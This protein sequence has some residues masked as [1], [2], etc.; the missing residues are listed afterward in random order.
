MRADFRCTGSTEESRFAWEQEIAGTPFERHLSS[1][2]GRDQARARPQGGTEVR[3]TSRHAPEGALAAGIPDAEPRPGDDHR[4][5][6]GR[7]RESADGR[8]RR[9]IGADERAAARC[10]VVGLGRSGDRARDRRRRPGRAPRGDRRA[11]SPPRGRESLDRG[12]AAPGKAGPRGGGRGGRRGMGP[13]SAPRTGSATPPA[14]ATRTWPGCA[15]A[16][17][18]PRPTQSCC[19][20]TRPSCRRCWRPARRPGSPW[21]PSAGAPAWSAGSSRCGAAIRP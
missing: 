7:H 14:A 13:R 15:R 16:G 1:S 4:R 21:S 2:R 3:I 18:R 8:R 20:P 17:S 10:E 6:A 19:R 9:R 11:S 12:R 5:G